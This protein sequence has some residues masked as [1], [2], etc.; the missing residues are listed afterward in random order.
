MSK[1]PYQPAQNYA[2]DILERGLASFEPD[3]KLNPQL[4]GWLELAKVEAMESQADA[5]QAL[6]EATES[7]AM[8][9]G[10][11]VP[12]EPVYVEPTS[13]IANDI[14]AK[15]EQEALCVVTKYRRKP[16]EHCDAI[17]PGRIL[18]CGVSERPSHIHCYP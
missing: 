3:G 13:Q 11:A 18:N 9:T 10:S 12:M 8:E 1:I 14:R 17:P 15:Q 7:L 6:A 16:H 5:S 4:A 2:R